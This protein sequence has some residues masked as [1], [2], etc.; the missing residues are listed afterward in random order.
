VLQILATDHHITY[1]H[2]FG[3]AAS[4]SG[5]NDTLHLV[6]LDEH[7]GGCRGGDFA[8]TRERRYHGLLMYQTPL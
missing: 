1:V 5:E 6:S 3:H 2:M 7:C 4:H 8:N